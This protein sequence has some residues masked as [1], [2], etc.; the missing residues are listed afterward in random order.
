MQ[1]LRL[2]HLQQPLLKLYEFGKIFSKEADQLIETETLAIFLTGN[3][4]AEN[5]NS[6]NKTTDFFDAKLIVEKIIKQ[7]GIMPSAIQTTP[8]CTPLIEGLGFLLDA[9]MIATVGLVNDSICNYFDIK[10]AVYYIEMNWE[11][12][13]INR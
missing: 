12:L 9:K 6:M 7:L 3:K 13:L 1:C 11:L 8:I 4:E 2:D 10:Q 5:W